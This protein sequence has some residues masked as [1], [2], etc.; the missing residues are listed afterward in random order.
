MFSAV[1]FLRYSGPLNIELAFHRREH[2][3]QSFAE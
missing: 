1:K 2:E 3:E